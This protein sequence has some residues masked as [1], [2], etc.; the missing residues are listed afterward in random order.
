MQTLRITLQIYIFLYVKHRG[1][2]SESSTYPESE[3]FNWRF[4]VRNSLKG[5]YV[6]TFPRIETVTSEDS[7]L[8]SNFGR[9]IFIPVNLRED[10]Q[11]QKKTQHYA[12][13]WSK[14]LTITHNIRKK[15]ELISSNQ[16]RILQLLPW[17]Q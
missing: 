5:K 11:Q 1:L 6:A 8:H 14:R 13:N 4:S 2:V 9:R 10:E 17:P 12:S 15:Q 16:A 3:I 7:L